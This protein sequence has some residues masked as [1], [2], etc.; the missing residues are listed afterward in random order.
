MMPRRTLK[1]VGLSML[2]LILLTAV[3]LSFFNWNWL[4]GPLEHRFLE[5][6]GRQLV[7]GGDLRVK[8]GFP[9]AHVD[10]GQ[11]TFA[12]PTWAMEKQMLTADHVAFSIDLPAL[13][14]GRY[15][16]P[17]VE[18]VRPVLDLERSTD[19]RANWHL[20]PEQQG[21][22]SKF[23]MGLL[24][25]DAGKL[26]YDDPTESTSVRADVSTA[27]PGQSATGGKAGDGGLVFIASGKH[28]GL[29]FT[30]R[31]NGGPVLALSKETAPYPIVLEASVGQSSIRADGTITGLLDA[32]A[33]IDMQVNAKG[34][35]LSSLFP[36]LA[37]ALPDT[38]PYSLAG[39]LLHDDHMWRFEKFSGHIGKS[40][41]AGTIQVDT[42]KPRA[43]L[44]GELV[45]EHLHFADL[46]PLVGTGPPGAAAVVEQGGAKPGS[47]RPAKV[48]ATANGGRVLPRRPY[49]SERWTS[50]D[51]EV[52]FSAHKINRA[53]ELPLQNLVTVIKLHDSVLT[54]DPLDFGIAGGH[55][56]GIITLDGMQNPIAAKATMYARKLLLGEI[57]P[58][59]KLAQQ[60]V[61][62]INGEINLA[63]SGNTV[64]D[65]L[66]SADGKVAFVTGQGRVSRLLM[67]QIGLHLPEIVL[68]K[69][70]GDEIVGVRCGVADFDVRHGVMKVD[71]LVLD[72]EVNTIVG[73]GTV[74]LGQEKIDLTVVPHT[75]KTSLVALRAPIHV[76]GSLGQPEISLDTAKAAGRG[77]GAIALG[78]LNP[79]LALLPLV[80]PAK[81]VDT[82]CSRLIR[83]AK[84]PPTKLVKKPSASAANLAKHASGSVAER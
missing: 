42:D 81:E 27:T 26:L 40:D 10:A 44:H 77:L 59:V 54:L 61:G 19:A 28:K 2:C 23:R 29:P 80:D 22:H 56:E 8:L 53:E 46:G 38:N 66:A 78:L 17:E 58:T 84:A 68:L 3:A 6:T 25:L 18:L 35:S 13:L 1:W 30:A 24:R 71:S 5:R 31:G 14:S 49:Q 67:E 83:E 39:H 73:F 52:K 9:L 64:S 47:K 37:L 4:K 69:V 75:K 34:D 70:R 41:L 57:L 15:L 55:L 20:D 63:G 82:D 50:L 43:F 48:I 33:Q 79:F 51:A 62:Q 32:A 65:M 45:S 11:V 74:D 12:N 7:I 72:T 21:G 36:Q 16:L 76:R 60:T